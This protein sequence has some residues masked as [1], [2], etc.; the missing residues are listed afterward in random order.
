MYPPWEV[1]GAPAPN[2]SVYESMNLDGDEYEALKQEFSQPITL[3]VFAVSASVGLY[4][5]CTS[6]DKE[7]VM[8]RS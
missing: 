4:A 1:K 2:L 5:L 7:T 6:H 3:A 8:H